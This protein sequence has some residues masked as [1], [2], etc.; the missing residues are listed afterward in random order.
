MTI[1][2]SVSNFYHGDSNIM[3]ED[4]SSYNKSDYCLCQ[5]QS[6]INSVMIIMLN[7]FNMANN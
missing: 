6:Q 5:V 2:S 7:L 4:A 3:T 1:I